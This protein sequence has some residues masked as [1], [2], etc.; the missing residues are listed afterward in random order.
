MLA[1]MACIRFNFPLFP[2]AGGHQQR[3]GRGGPHAKWSYRSPEDLD[4]EV[5]VDHNTVT[6]GAGPG[7][8]HGHES[9]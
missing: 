2:S 7:E 8:H 3:E 1:F 5:K 6:L 9:F 4:R